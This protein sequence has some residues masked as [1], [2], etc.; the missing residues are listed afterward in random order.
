MATRADLQYHNLKI[1]WEGAKAS[2]ITMSEV[3]V[4]SKAIHAFR[5]ELRALKPK[6]V[7]HSRPI[8]AAQRGQYGTPARQLIVSQS[9]RPLVDD[10]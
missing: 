9:E 4:V 8:R 7:S 5:P 6:F 1:V 10:Q 3:T 2:L